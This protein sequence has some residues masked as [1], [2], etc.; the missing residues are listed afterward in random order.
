MINISKLP[1]T[2][3]EFLFKNVTDGGI[4]K[5]VINHEGKSYEIHIKFTAD[6]SDVTIQTND[7]WTDETETWLA[8]GK[9]LRQKR[10]GPGIPVLEL[11][12]VITYLVRHQ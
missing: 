8:T 4:S 6:G 11:N 12:R 1:V 10:V 7:E 9:G 3:K 2:V 5:F